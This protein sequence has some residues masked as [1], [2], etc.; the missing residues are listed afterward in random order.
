M[1]SWLSG[2]WRQPMTIIEGSGREA[3]ITV[4]IQRELKRRGAVVHKV[5]GGVYGRRGEP[6][7][8][9]CIRGR[10]FAFEVKRPGN[11]PTKLQLARLV[12]WNRADAITGVV[13]SASKVVEALKQHGVL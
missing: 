5:V 1:P 7:L 11:K 13:Y 12:E 3:A 2:F 10:C 6:D 8:I 9:G 4:S